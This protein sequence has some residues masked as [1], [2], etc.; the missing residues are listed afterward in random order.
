MALALQMADD[1]LG[2]GP[3]P[4]SAEAPLT[5]SPGSLDGSVQLSHLLGVPDP[6]DMSSSTQ[7]GSWGLS[8]NLG[9]ERHRVALFCL[10]PSPLL[11]GG[12]EG[13]RAQFSSPPTPPTQSLAHPGPLGPGHSRENHP[14]SFRFRYSKVISVMI[15]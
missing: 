7:I 5:S 8:C 10:W 11:T 15:S 4:P 6:S 1:R 2:L 3:V 13:L 9:A 14:T 12:L